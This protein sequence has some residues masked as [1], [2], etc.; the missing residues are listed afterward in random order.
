MA[1]SKVQATTRDDQVKG[2]RKRDHQIKGPMDDQIKGPSDGPLIM[3]K[4]TTFTNATQFRFKS[5]F[6]RDFFY[7]IRI[8]S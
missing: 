6:L 4:D 3:T 2:T 8:I 5:K 7:S 1:R